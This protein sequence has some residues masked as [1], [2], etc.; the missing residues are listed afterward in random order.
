[1]KILYCGL[2]YNYGKKDESFS[3]EHYNIEAGF[4]NCLDMGIFDHVDFYY[5]DTVDDSSRDTLL[6]RIGSNSYDCI[7]H[8]AFNETLDLPEKAANLAISKNP[9]LLCLVFLNQNSI[10]KLVVL[11]LPFKG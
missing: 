1:M 10:V 2:L 4:R 11:K 7:F 3:Y 6:V 5:P 8:V 9:W